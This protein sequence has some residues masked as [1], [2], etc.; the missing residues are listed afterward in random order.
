M[1]VSKSFPPVDSHRLC[2]S[3]PKSNCDTMCNTVSISR[4]S[5]PKAPAGGWSCRHPL[6]S[7][8]QEP[9]LPNGKQVFSLYHIVCINSLGTVSQPYQLGNGGNPPEILI[10]RCQLRTKVVN[11]PF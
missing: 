1:Q 3:P 9:R 6:S 4:N 2:I 8:H 10:H 7:M 5:L 11:G